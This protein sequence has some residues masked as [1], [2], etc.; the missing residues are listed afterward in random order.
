[1][2]KST[3]SWHYVSILFEINYHLNLPEIGFTGTNVT[4]LN[5]TCFR[6]FQ[7]LLNTINES[8]NN[9]YALTKVVP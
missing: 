5:V 3:A 9:N 7:S 8:I 1:M 4:R 2:T 6:F